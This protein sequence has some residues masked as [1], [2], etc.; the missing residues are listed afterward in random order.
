MDQDAFGEVE[1]QFAANGAEAALEMV[2][3]TARA[4]KDYHMLFGARAMEARRRLGLPLIEPESAPELADEQRATYEAALEAAAREAG[5]LALRHGDVADAWPY[6]KALG[7]T[8]AIAAAI[9]NV[10]AGE[11]LDRVIEI[12][13]QEGVNVRRGF[14]LI[15]ENRGICNAITWFPAIRDAGVRQMCLRLLV[16]SLYQDL[17]RSLAET[18]AAA[19]GTAPATGNVAE[20]IAGRPA[21]FEGRSYY[22]DST[23][24][25]ALLRFAPE[26]EDTETM[27]MAAE[28]ADYGCCLDPIYHFRGDPPFDQPYRDCSMYLHTLLGEDRDAGVAHFRAKAAAGNFVCAEVFIELLLRL[29]RRAE[30]L[31]AA[32]EF[33][34]QLASVPHL[35]QMAGDFARLRDIAR[36]RGDLLGFAAAVIQ[37]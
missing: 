7:D 2:A 23:H 35:C 36:E 27:R 5:D 33:T 16:Q 12:A 18:I 32:L 13:F 25:S 34:P 14:E 9:E 29:G 19:D 3:R 11:Q 28:M 15:L 24:L 20:L 37:G 6:F 22:V 10:G 21:L 1:R 8:A 31:A 17:A 30:A 4:A 26:L